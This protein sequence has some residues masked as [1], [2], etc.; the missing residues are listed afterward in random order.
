MFSMLVI[1]MAVPPAAEPPPRPETGFGMPASTSMYLPKTVLE[2]KPFAAELKLTEDQQKTVKGFN[3]KLNADIKDAHNRTTGGKTLNDVFV[4]I[5]KDMDDT[6]VKLLTDGQ[7]KRHRQLVWQSLEASEGAL[8]VA[9]NPVASRA[10]GFTDDQKK[11][12]E[13]WVKEHKE[14]PRVTAWGGEEYREQIK[15][16][17]EKSKAIS[18]KVVADLTAAQK[19]KW[20]ELLGEPFKGPDV[21]L[22]PGMRPLKFPEPKK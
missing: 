15:A 22:Q 5:A 2:K 20:D 18:D 3:A 8:R 19:A 4:E 16:S 6:I 10:I 1:A 9:A 11:R 14:I 12:I 13:G 17:Q 7:A 21:I